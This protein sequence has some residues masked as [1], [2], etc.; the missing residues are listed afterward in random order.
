MHSAAWGEREA[1][2][3]QSRDS[4]RN[5]AHSECILAPSVSLIRRVPSPWCPRCLAVLFLFLV[6]ASVGDAQGVT[7]PQVGGPSAVTIDG[8]PPPVPPAVVSRDGDGRVTIRAVRIEQALELDGRLDEAVYQSVLPVSDFIQQEPREGDPA[9]ERTEAW[10]FFDNRNV[11]VAV[12]CWDSQ[13]D[14]I[15]ANEMRRDNINIFNNDSLT[16]VF[17]TYYDRRSGFFFQTNALGALRDGL[18]VGEGNTNYDWSTVWEVQSRRFDRGWITEIAIPFKSLRYI[19]HRE[20]IWGVNLRRTVRWKNET[21]HVTRIP[22]SYTVRGVTKFSS[23]ATLVGIETPSA[24]RNVELKPYAISA[25]TTNREVQP[26]ISNDLDGDFGFDAK[27]GLTR[28]LIVDLTYNTD[29][30]QV[31]ADEQQVNLTRFNLQFPEKREFFLEGRGIFEFGGGG[32]APILFFSRQI[33][34]NNGRTVPIRAGGRLTGRVGKYSL[35]V[36][37]IQTQDSA[38]AGAVSTNFSVVRLK[39]DLLRR[40][41][42]G[43]M[44]TG[45]FPAMGTSGS[46]QV[47]GVDAELRFFQDLEINSYY[48]RTRTP[49]LSGNDASYQAQLLYLPDR[50]GVMLDHLKVG[51]SFNPEIGFLRRQDFTR[52]Y[53]QLRF[54]PRPASLNGVRKLTWQTSLE[55]IAG[56]DGRLET[57]EA[58]ASF[59]VDFDNGDIATLGYTSNYELLRAPFRI[60][61]G[62]VLPVGGYPFNEVSASYRPG[63]QRRVSQGAVTASRGSFYSGDRTTLGYSSRAELTSQLSV[64][65]RV[66]LNWVDLPEGSFTTKLVGA[67]T[68]YTVTPRMF[69]GALIQFNSTANALTTNVRFRWEYQPGSDVFVVFSEGRDT[70]LRASDPVA[71]RGFAIKYTRLFR[72]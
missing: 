66:S 3:R 31:E 70:Q 6:S 12:R 61:P 65:P 69:V 68:T 38:S 39:R 27:Y 15:T 8:P 47:I 13:P 35:G 48:A 50:Y 49:T 4:A 26:A 51:E 29:F 41:A 28:S 10:I 30:A 22:A 11:Y 36:L 2:L 53:G 42:V 59:G 37:N 21:V 34:L 63:P 40:S 52:N 45:R 32:E 43:V 7:T 58:V 16:V 46:N 25:L 67:R 44:A 60:A 33:G 9:T 17:D 18:V 24:S 1:H 23:A 54:S 64:E 20:Q 56:G 57:R 5:G 55:H 14:R 72:F 62:I 19:E 71:N